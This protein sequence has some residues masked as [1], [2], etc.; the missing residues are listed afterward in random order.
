M[1]VGK[2]LQHLLPFPCGS[3]CFCLLCFVTG[4]ANALD[5]DPLVLL[6]ACCWQLCEHCPELLGQCFLDDVWHFCL[7][8]ILM[9]LLLFCSQ[10]PVPADPD[11]VAMVSSKDRSLWHLHHWWNHGVVWAGKDL[12]IPAF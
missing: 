2:S 1:N 6:R 5:L 4:D 3:L 8:L 12:N 10:G 11:R 7:H 9:E